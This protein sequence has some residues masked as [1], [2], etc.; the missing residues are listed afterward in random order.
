[1]AKY[2]KVNYIGNKEK[3]VNWIIEEM[4]V[5]S[6]TILDIF[7]GGCSVSYALKN[8]GYSVIANDILYADYVIAKALVENS[9]TKLS[10]NVFDKKVSEQRVEELAEKFS[11][12]SYCLY[13][14]E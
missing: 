2:P 12:I 9:D 5:K 10:V 8:S 6:G 11:F 7:A 3:L 4:P 14:T 1:M 13:Y